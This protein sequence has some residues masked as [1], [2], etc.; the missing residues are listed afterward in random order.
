MLF[1]AFSIGGAKLEERC[2]RHPTSLTTAVF[3]LP[4]C[5]RTTDVLDRT[6][7]QPRLKIQRRKATGRL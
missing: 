6:V 7:S 2:L 5:Y 4:Q 1:L 3:L